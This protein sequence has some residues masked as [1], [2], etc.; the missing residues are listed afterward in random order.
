MVGGVLRAEGLAVNSTNDHSCPHGD[1]FL[2]GRER[3]QMS[4]KYMDSGERTGTGERV[5]WGRGRLLHS[6][7]GQARTLLKGDP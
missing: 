4:K 1:H 3:E 5:C 7:G 2:V 6:Q